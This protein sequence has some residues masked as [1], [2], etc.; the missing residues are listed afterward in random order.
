MRLNNIELKFNYTDNGQDIT[1]EGSIFTDGWQQW[2]Q[3]KEIL[4]E[5][6]NLIEA[7][8]NTVHEIIGEVMGIEE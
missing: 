5:N 1:I 6:V 2:G 7:I 4:A 8:N 3:T